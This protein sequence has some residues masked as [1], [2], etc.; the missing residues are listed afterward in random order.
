GDDRG[1]DLLHDLARDTT[2]GDVSRVEVA[3]KLV[4]L[5]DDRGA[6]LLHDLA[7]DGIVHGIVRVWAAEKL[8][9]RFG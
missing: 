9:K 2:L 5:G 3:E 1:A 8:A 7:L 6:D 4:G